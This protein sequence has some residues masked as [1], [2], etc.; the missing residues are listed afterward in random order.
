MPESNSVLCAYPPIFFPCLLLSLHWSLT[1]IDLIKVQYFFPLQKISLKKK[2]STLSPAPENK[3]IFGR[4]V[5]APANIYQYSSLLLL[6]EPI[7]ELYCVKDNTMRHTIRQDIQLTTPTTIW[8]PFGPTQPRY[9]DI[10]LE[11]LFSRYW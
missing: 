11:I 7:M 8:S 3:N 1:A 5:P 2:K 10:S 4:K 9:Q 6:I